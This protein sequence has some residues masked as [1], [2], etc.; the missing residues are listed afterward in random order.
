MRHTKSAPGPSGLFPSG[1]V[2][3]KLNTR[4]FPSLRGPSI[5]A[6]FFLNSS[7]CPLLLFVFKAASKVGLVMANMPAIRRTSS[8]KFAIS[9]PECGVPKKMTPLVESRTVFSCTS[10]PVE[11]CDILRAYRKTQSESPLQLRIFINRTYLQT[12]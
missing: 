6:K 11:S 5:L 9:E 1:F 4:N 12:S 2:S 8:P 3:R 7:N 10:A